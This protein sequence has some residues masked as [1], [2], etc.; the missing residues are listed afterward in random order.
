MQVFDKVKNILVEE[1]GND[2]NDITPESSISHVVYGLGT[3]S[4]VAADMFMSVEQEFQIEIP[5][6]QIR[7]M[8]TIRDLVNFIES[9]TQTRKYA[10]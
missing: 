5:K 8:I 4:I 6:K 3:D 1:L 2:E 7:T 9:I 10:Y